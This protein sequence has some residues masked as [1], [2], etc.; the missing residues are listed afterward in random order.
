MRPT[1]PPRWDFIY[2]REPF[3]TTANRKPSHLTVGGNSICVRGLRG[4]GW[5]IRGLVSRLRFL[6]AS[7][8][9]VASV[10]GGERLCSNN[11][12]PCLRVALSINGLGTVL[13]IIS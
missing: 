8:K 5:R 9:G 2:H 13:D 3:G 6:P 12:T 1:R 10:Q 4:P 7:S 11:R